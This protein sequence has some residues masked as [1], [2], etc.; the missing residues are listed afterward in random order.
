MAS[1]YAHPAAVAPAEI[2]ASGA[3]GIE[4]LR[5]QYEVARRNIDAMIAR[6]I[7]DR[8]NAENLLASMAQAQHIPRP[9]Y[10]PTQDKV[11]TTSEQMG[12]VIEQH[13]ACIKV[14]EYF[15]AQMAL[16]PFA[17]DPAAKLLYETIICSGYQCVSI[18]NAE[19]ILG[20]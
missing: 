4:H 19:N 10:D 8:D 6:G 17:S 3:L 15:Q 20:K 18:Y 13:R 9:P 14:F 11:G 7:I 2:G 1:P 16:D 5:R 12:A